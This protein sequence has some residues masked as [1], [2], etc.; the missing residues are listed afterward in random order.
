MFGRLV[1]AQRLGVKFLLTQVRNLNGIYF[2]DES[3]EDT[4]D[5]RTEGI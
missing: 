2:H 5:D 4:Y 3:Y 1:Y